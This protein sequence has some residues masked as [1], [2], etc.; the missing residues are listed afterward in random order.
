MTGLMAALTAGQLADL[1]AS[2]AGEQYLSLCP[3]TRLIDTTITAVPATASFAQVTCVEGVWANVRIGQTVLIAHVD[4][5]RTA[6]FRG[7]VRATPAGNVLYINATSAAIEIGDYLWV[8]DD[9]AIFVKAARD[10]GA[11]YYKDWDEAYRLPRP[12]IYNLKSAYAG[13]VAAGTGVLTLALAPLAQATNPDATAVFT[14]LWNVADGTITVGN[15]NTQN[16][17]V[18]FP[19]TDA[20]R[21]IHLTVTDSQG[22]AQTFHVFVAAHDDAHPP[23][24]GFTGAEITG[25]LDG[26]WSASVS[27]FDDVDTVLD[28]TL[29]VI[30]SREF[31]G[32]VTEANV[33]GLVETWAVEFVGRLRKEADQGRSDTELAY[34][35]QVNFEIEGPAAQLARLDAA[36]LALRNTSAPAVWDE[37]ETL[38]VWRAVAHLLETTST[39]LTVHALSFDDVTASFQ[40]P[41]L[42]TEDSSLYGAVNALAALIDAAL[43]FAPD[44]RCLVPRNLRYTT[45]VT[46]AAATVVADWADEDLIDLDLDHDHERLIGA[47]EAD[48]GCYGTLTDT[49][50]PFLSL[51]PGVQADGPEGKASLRSQVLPRNLSDADAQTELNFRCGQ[52]LDADNP[53]DRLTITFPPGYHVLIPSRA[54]VHTWTLDGGTNVRGLV[55]TDAENWLLVNL[56]RR[57]DNE[58]GTKEVQ[59][60]F[61]YLPDA[62]AP[63][64]TVTYPAT[65]EIADPLAFIPT[66]PPFPTFPELPEITLPV[67]PTLED[68]QPTLPR[69]DKTART[70]GSKNGNTVLVWTADTLWLSLNFLSAAPEYADVTPGTGLEI[71]HAIFDPTDPNEARAYCLIYD[72]V[73]V[74]SAVYRTADV[75]ANPPAWT[76]GGAVA[77]EWSILR[78]GST[79]GELYI[80]R[81]GTGAAATVTYDF[82]VDNGG[83]SSSPVNRA[84]YVAGTGWGSNAARLDLVQIQSPAFA[85]MYIMQILITYTVAVDPAELECRSNDLSGS[86]HLGYIQTATSTLLVNP[87]NGAWTGMWINLDADE[88]VYGGYITGVEITGFLGGG[89]AETR[90]ST[91]YG[92]TMAAAVAVGASPGAVLPLD[93]IKVG[94]VVLSGITAQVR[95]ATAGGAYGNEANGALVGAN[96]FMILVPF[97]DF[98]ALTKNTSDATPEYLLGADVIDTAGETLYYVTDA[99]QTAITPSSGGVDGVPV[100]PEAA[101]MSF[102]NGTKIALLARVALGA[103]HLFTTI[104]TGGAWTDRGAIQNLSRMVRMRRTDSAAVQLFIAAGADGPTYSPDFGATLITKPWPSTDAVKGCEVY[105]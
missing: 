51:A 50:T 69:L 28:N 9:Y 23:A 18:T 101:A 59:G 104:N 19:A 4:D 82:T 39:F 92:A 1:R 79:A 25:D 57:H 52:A 21:W 87:A 60:T 31:Y 100:G 48:G 37:L 93:T 67:D 73:A 26:G 65:A 94:N 74:T 85:A 76:A 102:A 90:Y 15:V 72:S 97:R 14:W 99:G 64:Q 35:S 22:T 61:E 95:T 8:L 29:C 24:L 88:A 66:F 11:G 83:W 17:T 32:A 6:F 20:Q 96:P 7:Y 5:E 43:E 36:P 103:A 40:Q 34:S 30:W 62:A 89:G 58:A 55:F 91:D 53:H 45:D 44:G 70:A 16:I 56:R 12:L 10:T 71:K 46:R 77:G 42:G 78:L 47:V 63:G 41:L 68:S 80:G 27:A 33:G 98:G 86:G 2:Y 38:T 49:V 75:F 3:N 81:P 84:T 105:G 54:A 13:W